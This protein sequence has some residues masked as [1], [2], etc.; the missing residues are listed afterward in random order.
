MRHIFTSILLLLAL[1]ACQQ[2]AQNQ[3]VNNT[4]NTPP[5]WAQSA[6]WYQIFVERF[7][8][9][10][11]SNDPTPETMYAA[12]NFIP[13]PDNWTITP[14]T[15]DWYEQEEWAQRN[16]QNF[17][18]NLQL[19]RYGGD[20]QGVLDK[21]D[22][23]QDLGITA[24]YFNPLNDAP[25]LHKYD[26]RNYHHID[27]NFGPDPQGDMTIIAS[28]T[29]DD[30]STWQW[31][32]A[33]KMFLQVI[34]EAHKRDIKVI[35]DYSWNHTGVEFWVW[36]DIVKN[37][38]KSE[39][40]DW[41]IINSF[42]DPATPQNEFNYEGWLDIQSLP[43]L[44][45]IDAPAE[46][47]P[48]HPFEG[49]L[50]PQV[51]EH[52]FAVTKRWLAP[53]GDVSKGLDGYRLDVAD[54]IPMGFWREYHHFVKSINPEA[55]LVG[56][57]WWEEWP[58]KLMNPVPYVSGDVF[59]AV[60]FYQVYRPARYFF[61]LTD[62]E[63]D[64]AQLVDSLNFQWDRIGDATARGMMNTAATHDTPRLL[65]SFANKGKYKYQAKPSDNPD[66]ITGKPDEETYQ[67]VKLYLLHQFTSVGAPHIWNG[68]EMGMW[69]ADD[70]DC[71]KPLWW[72]EYNFE[73]ENIHS[74]FKVEKQYVPVGFN[75][76]LHQYYKQMTRLRN[77]N[78]VLSSGT[79]EFVKAQG[80]LLAYTRTS[81]EAQLLVVFNAG[82]EML[83]YH[84]PKGKQ[85][86]DLLTGKVIEDE[87]VVLKSI[88]GLVL[89]EM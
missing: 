27:V 53:D 12:S 21:L 87:M 17:Y 58:D 60:M 51:K 71:R 39:F 72:P 11:P 86:K 55:Y 33:D 32:S 65:T 16:V 77:N 24:I 50:H 29:P 40:K 13:T 25:S 68:D 4:S 9:G 34:E 14:W 5:A 73:P 23:L 30:P 64:A 49:N 15:Q 44:T 1:S 89:K 26:A 41:Y 75:T 84:L 57:I 47:K 59:D 79:L 19:R 82:N 37:Q 80:K 28:E 54:H 66:Y 56:E 67:R 61:A 18:S 74:I 35:L 42:D 81:Q 88:S 70:P 10:D 48:G 20:L 85:Y 8:N 45:K 7:N 2:P 36:K 69:G 83:K 78:P 22:Y 3:A 76:E 63:I 52:V 6:I 38:E 62:F 31:T 43:A 46:H